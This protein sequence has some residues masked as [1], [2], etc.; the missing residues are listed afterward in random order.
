MYEWSNGIGSNLEILPGAYLFPLEIAFD[1]FGT[2]QSM[3]DELQRIFYQPY[4]DCFR[5]LE[6][7]SDGGYAFGRIDSPSKGKI[8][9][10]CIHAK[11]QIAYN[12]LSDLLKTAIECYKR[13]AFD[14]PDMPDFKMYF[15]IGK[16]MNAPLKYWD[17]A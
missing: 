8:V 10:L 12:S 11:W 3:K 6:D 7:Y 5:F 14:D 17:L 1:Q 15:R 13:G 9:G 2:L 16:E 4:Y